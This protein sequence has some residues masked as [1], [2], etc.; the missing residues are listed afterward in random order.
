MSGIRFTA[1]EDEILRRN[2]ERHT[3][4][5]MARMLSETL[6]VER[7]VCAVSDRCTKRLGIKRGVNTGEFSKGRR[8]RRGIG[9]E[10]VSNGYTYVKVAD[11]YF[12]GGTSPTGY[13]A[14]NWSAKQRV[15][16][17]RANG[18]SVPDGYI[19]I[20]VDG[21]TE[22]FD[23]GN[24]ACISRKTSAILSSNG[25]FSGT[26]EIRRAAIRYC[27]LIEALQYRRERHGQG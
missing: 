20:F 8:E 2:V 19:V 9:A 10:V 14:P 1:A 18:K 21:D 6:G 13:V 3:Y 15:V 7:S 24:L 27:E 17:E 12:E 22:N 5:E 26:P 23:P 16:W 4:A 25:W 11:E